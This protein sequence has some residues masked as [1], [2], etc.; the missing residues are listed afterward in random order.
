MGTA[1]GD[2]PPLVG[3][4]ATL[5]WPAMKDASWFDE[6]VDYRCFWSEMHVSE[7]FDMSMRLQSQ[8]YCGRY[9]MYTGTEFQEGVSIS[10]FDEIIKLKKYSYG[11]GEMLFNKFKDWPCKG[12]FSPLITKFMVSGVRWDVKVNI[13]SYLF[14]YVAMTWAVILTPMAMYVSLFSDETKHMQMTSFE[15]LAG[16][17]II[18]FMVGSTT[19]ILYCFFLRRDNSLITLSLTQLKHIPIVTIFFSGLLYHIAVGLFRY[20]FDLSA[21]WGA[22]SKEM[23]NVEYTLAN[24]CRE[25]YET[26]QRYWFMY[27]LCFLFA[28][29]LVV[30]YATPYGPVWL[31]WDTWAVSPFIVMVMSHAL[32][33]I[34]LN[35]NAM[36]SLFYPLFGWCC[37]CCCSRS[38]K[39]DLEKS[40]AKDSEI[41]DTETGREMSG[42]DE[43]SSSSGDLELPRATK[44]YRSN[45][46]LKSYRTK[47]SKSSRTS[48]LK[49]SRSNGDLKSSRTSDLKSSRTKDSK[50]S[51]ASDLKS[52]RSSNDLK[53]SR[54]SD[55]KSSRPSNDLKSNRSSR[56]RDSKSY[57]TN[58][59]KSYRSRSE[60]KSYRSSL[61]NGSESYPNDLEALE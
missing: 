60:L 22:T 8:G 35:A 6:D 1:N 25:L 2:S 19:T 29:T 10:V 56:T 42:R 15:I 58:D 54:T 4:N 31:E 52:S 23:D 57:R 27:I 39:D 46:D 45:N 26:I 61:T 18:F 55:L 49:S 38:K 41:E 44:S 28:A 14:T 40:S 5:S 59:L 20:M 12:P 3:H 53:S 13:L 51:R 47:D 17:F 34:L 36:Y 50:S 24:F 33:P 43:S 21:E 48:E 9:I 32:M 11:T 16:C 37:C 30:L 7:D